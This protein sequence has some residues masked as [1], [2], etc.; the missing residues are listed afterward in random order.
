MAKKTKESAATKSES[1]ALTV[2]KDNNFAIAELDA[3]QFANALREN[4]GDEKL[5]QQDLDK[6]KIPTGDMS[7]FMVPDLEEGEKA[8][9][10]IL[11]VIV[12]YRPARAYWEKSIDD[13]GGNTPPDC[14]SNDGNTGIGTPGGVCAVCPFNEFESAKK[15]KGKACNE[16]KL[17]FLMM[18]DSVMPRV[19][20]LPPTS[21]GAFKKYLTR[22]TSG[23][24]PY[25]AVVTEIGLTPKTNSTGQAYFEASFR[26]AKKLTP[27]DIAHMATII[28]PLRGAFETQKIDRDG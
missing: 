20:S 4:F 9:K 26:M 7:M 14:Y 28:D 24:V 21:L 16:R 2:L 18:P 1:V 3:D 15:G 8:V 19:L 13:G 27:E 25:P 12:V 17:L 10:T 11:A 6:I 22:L 23:I 5:G